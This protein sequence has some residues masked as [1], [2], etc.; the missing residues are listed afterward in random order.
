MS[1]AIILHQ[2]QKWKQQHW[3]ISPDAWQIAG[4]HTP[5]EPWN[6]NSHVLSVGDGPIGLLFGP[7]CMQ[8][9]GRFGGYL[10]VA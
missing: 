6:R 2:S 9:I 10:I 3:K 8:S 5:Q 4:A 1:F 7:R